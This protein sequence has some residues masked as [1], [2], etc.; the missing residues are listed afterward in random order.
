MEYEDE[1]P[2]KKR[3]G[4]KEFKE[5]VEEA[6]KNARKKP[7]KPRGKKA[8]KKYKYDDMSAKEMYTLVKQ[9][10]DMI[11]EKRGIPA[12]IPRGK[13]ALIQIC[14]RIKA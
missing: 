2:K 11:L 4:R 8:A 10:R 5:D 13:A 3:V 14:K 6:I 7:K 12:K 9:K 1:R